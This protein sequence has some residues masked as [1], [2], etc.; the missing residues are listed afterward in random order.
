MHAL[1]AVLGSR[2]FLHDVLSH[3]PRDDVRREDKMVSRPILLGIAN[4]SSRP[5]WLR[6]LLLSSALQA[7]IHGRTG[8]AARNRVAAGNAGRERGD[9]HRCHF[10]VGLDAL[11]APGGEGLGNRNRPTNM[12][13]AIRAACWSKASHIADSVGKFFALGETWRL[14]PGRPSAGSPAGFSP[15]TLMPKVPLVAA[16]VSPRAPAL[17]ADCL[18][19]APRPRCGCYH[20]ARVVRG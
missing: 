16:G 7:V 10:L 4:R 12:M 11:P 3:E 17:C 19:V 9:A 14:K 8:E 2:C 1:H 13:T 6:R 5:A 15:T 18:P 20:R